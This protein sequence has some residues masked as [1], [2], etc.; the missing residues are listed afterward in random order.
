MFSAT[1]AAWAGIVFLLLTTW[2]SG[3]RPATLA[4]GVS[5]SKEVPSGV[6]SPNDVRNMQQILYN[7]GHYRGKIDGVFG[8]RTQAS[9][10]TF[11]KAENL[12]LTGRLDTQTAGT[13]GI[14]LDATESGS[15]NSGQAIG[16]DSAE[17][18]RETTKDK[19]SA[20][21]KWAKGSGRSRKTRAKAVT[22]ASSPENVRRDRVQKLQ[23]E[24]ENQP[25]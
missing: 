10:R 24:N 9:I 23:A 20:G 15:S 16:R 12:S 19:P 5:L 6:I 25:H 11:Q 13:L 4:S 17:T 14:T 1:K 8:L 3:P 18:G 22:T 2:V 7:R 21:I